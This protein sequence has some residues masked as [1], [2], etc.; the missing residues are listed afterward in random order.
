MKRKKRAYDWRRM[1]RRDRIGE[2]EVRQWIEHG[3]PAELRDIRVEM[4][5]PWRRGLATLTRTENGDYR[6]QLTELGQ[7]V[8]ELN[9]QRDAPVCKG[10]GKSSG[11]IEEY[12][13]VNTITG[14]D[15]VDWMH[16]EC[17]VALPWVQ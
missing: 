8:G 17:F 14:S 15:R 1:S 4:A 16:E 7:S 3:G 5:E 2:Q 9:E 11:V 10:C 6:A 12:M 13:V